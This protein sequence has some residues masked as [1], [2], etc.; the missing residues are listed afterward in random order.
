MLKLSVIWCY[1][2]SFSMAEKRIQRIWNYFEDTL[3]SK[4]QKGEKNSICLI[5]NLYFGLFGRRKFNI[6]STN[7]SQNMITNSKRP[8]IQNFPHNKMTTHTQCV[9]EPTLH[10]FFPYPLFPHKNSCC[11]T[12]PPIPLPPPQPHFIPSHISHKC[13]W[14]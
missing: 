11:Y 12:I 3:E 7:L 1:T 9:P 4:I 10:L 2:W 14:K 5:L 8:Y 6:Y 13:L